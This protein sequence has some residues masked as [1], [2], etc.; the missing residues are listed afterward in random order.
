MNN[1]IAQLAHSIRTIA[2]A[3]F[4]A[5]ML[6]ACNSQATSSSSNLVVAEAEQETPAIPVETRAAVRADISAIYAGTAALEASEEASVVAKVSGEI[7]KILVEEG[8]HVKA[9]QVLARLDGDYLRLEMEQA[10]ANLAKLE[11]DY[12]RNVE[13]HNKGLVAAGAFENLKFEVDS[14]KT[15]FDLAKL[16]YSYTEIR[17]PISGVVSA[18]NIK[19]GNTV[20]VGTPTFHIT[21]FEPLVAYL[22]V[23]EKEFGK[24]QPD[25]S[26]T[27]TVDAI[28]GQTFSAVVRRISPVVDSGTGTFKTTLEI[29]DRQQVLKPGMFGRFSIVYDTRKNSILI[30]RAAIIDS[31]LGKSVFIVSNDKVERRIIKTGFAQGENIEITQGIE[32]EDAVVT[33]GQSGLKDGSKVQVVISSPPKSQL[34]SMNSVNAVDS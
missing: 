12:N 8:D 31:E 19:T 9:G 15:A 13:L 25:Q 26:V 10:R 21:N 27:V 1:L 23:A 5:A 33:V 24:I 29:D 3:G 6:V 32:F 17:A 16:Q 18:R 28:N 34:A 14:Q 2:M 11:R 22:Y 20:E 7:R 30:P 4:I